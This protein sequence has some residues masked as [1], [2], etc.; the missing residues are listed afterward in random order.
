MNEHNTK[1]ASSY[2]IVVIN[3]YN[4]RKKKVYLYT[5]INFLTNLGRP[6]DNQLPGTEKKFPNHHF[7]GRVSSIHRVHKAVHG[8]DSRVTTHGCFRLQRQ[9]SDYPRL[10]QTTKTAE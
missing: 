1:L 7:L 4:G 6:C 10:F 9:Q 3:N 2:Y 5:L 8:A